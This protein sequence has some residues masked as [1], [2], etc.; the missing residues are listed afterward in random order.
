MGKGLVV[1]TLEAKVGHN[2]LPDIPLILVALQR[3]LP[4]VALL[5]GGAMLRLCERQLRLQIGQLSL[6]LGDFSA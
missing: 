6:A 3:P 1:F 5:S 2:H 4:L